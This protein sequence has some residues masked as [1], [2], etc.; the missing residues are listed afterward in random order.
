MRFQL[1]ATGHSSEERE[2]EAERVR[3]RVGERANVC[4]VLCGCIQFVRVQTRN[5]RT[6][7]TVYILHLAEH[8]SIDANRW[9][10]G[11]PLI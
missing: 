11:N 10:K 7:F 5:R 4:I 6:F 2:R 3:K 9:Q 1:L 8:L